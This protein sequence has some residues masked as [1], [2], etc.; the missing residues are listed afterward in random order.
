ME[1]ILIRHARP[2][3]IENSDA[4]ADP[5]LTELGHRQAR[6]VAAWMAAEPF[7]ALYTS[8]MQRARQTAAPLAALLGVE[9]VV[10]KGVR[11]YDDL[12]PSYIPLEDLKQDKEAWRA[13]LV[14]EAATDREDF[15]YEVVET[16]ERICTEHRRQ[17]VVVIC[18]GGVINIWASHVL[19][20]GD[21]MFFEPTYTC[22]NRFLAASSG[23]RSVVS[24]NETAH[25]RGWP[26]LRI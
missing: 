15:R 8:P 7:D 18:H 22:V 5:P 1:L 25:L 19:G 9:P 21:Q 14:E 11:E 20:L 26:D 12:A 17:K 13:W 4:P 3:R 10:E 2:E 6:A 16:L 23:E 24:L